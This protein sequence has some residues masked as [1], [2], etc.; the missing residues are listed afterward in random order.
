MPIRDILDKLRSGDEYMEVEQPEE[1][2][3]KSHLNIEVEHLD[4]FMDSERIQ[5]KLRE[6]TMLV[7]KMKDLKQKDAEELK[8]AVDKIKRTC[9]A[10]NGDIVG[11]SE[12]WLLATPAAAKIHR[13]EIAM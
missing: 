1:D 13:D 2:V 7:I 8:R 11:L 4:S 6:G 10:I 12:D 5:K 3:M 9:L